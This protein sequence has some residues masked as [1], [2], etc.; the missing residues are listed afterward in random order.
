MADKS[1]TNLLEEL[2]KS[3]ETTLSRF[4]YALGIR[5]VGETTARSLAEH[6]GNLRDLMNATEEQLLEVNDIGPVVATSIRQFF[7]D[8]RNR[9]LI[10]KLQ[11]DG[12]CWPEKAMKEKEAEFDDILKMGRTQL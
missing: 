12:V 6:F 3:R 10:R 8:A 2:Q 11:N 7:D 5:H 4:L 1:A 9:E